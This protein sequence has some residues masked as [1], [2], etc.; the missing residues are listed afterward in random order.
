MH[1]ACTEHLE[2]QCF[3]DFQLCLGDSWR[4]G[5]LPLAESSD[6]LKRQISLVRALSLPVAISQPEPHRLPSVR[7]KTI[8]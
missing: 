4:A 7:P 1:G 5:S 3:M 2:A 6:F 8:N